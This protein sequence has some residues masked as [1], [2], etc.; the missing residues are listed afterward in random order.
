[1]GG[2]PP[3]LHPPPPHRQGG[4]AGLGGGQPWVFAVFSK[5]GVFSRGHPPPGCP[6]VPSHPPLSCVCVS[7]SYL[8][9]INGHF[10][11]AA[12]LSGGENDRG[13]PLQYDPVH[14]QYWLR[15]GPPNS[16]GPRSAASPLPPETGWGILAPPPPR[17]CLWRHLVGARRRCSPDSGGGGP[18]RDTGNGGGTTTRTRHRGWDGDIHTAPI[19]R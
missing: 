13:P 15:L 4:G 3:T 10:S 19:G 6:C 18:S 17:L 1:M 8:L 5:I 12:A 7:P 16:G 14:P 11:G 2:A 9:P